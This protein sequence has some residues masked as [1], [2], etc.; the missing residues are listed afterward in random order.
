MQ[1]FLDA[2]GAE[3]DAAAFVPVFMDAVVFQLVDGAD[4]ALDRLRGGGL[5]LACVANWDI[6]LHEHLRRLDVHSRFAAVMTSAEAA[7]EKPDPA[8]FLMALDA[9]GVR[10][11]RALHIGDSDVDRDALARPGSRSSQPRWPRCP[12][13]SG[14]KTVSMTSEPAAERL[15]DPGGRWRFSSGSS[16]PGSNRGDLFAG[17]PRP[18]EEEPPIYEWSTAANALIV[19]GLLVLL[20]FG[21]ASMYPDTRRALGLRRFESRYL[22]H[23]AG[24]VVVSIVVAA[25]LEPILHAGEKQASRRR[26]G[27]RTTWRR[28]S[29][30]P[31]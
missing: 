11:G 2:A 13:G 3:L 23:A 1:V 7:A 9:I 22:W 27:G 19:Y 6:S 17:R 30:T 8:I 10:P 4:A 29:S 28:S 5:T 26:N 12:S 18:V 24:V 16:W 14:C 31:C 21:I 20:T 15:G 25:V